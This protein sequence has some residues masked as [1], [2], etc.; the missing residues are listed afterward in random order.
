MKNTDWHD[1]VTNTEEHIIRQIKQRA[2]RKYYNLFM[3][4]R[5]H[6]YPST[7]KKHSA[8]DKGLVKP[9]V[10]IEIEQAKKDLPGYD[11]MLNNHKTLLRNIIQI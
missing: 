5:R 9:K 3:F 11:T 7:I 2:M 1:I 6:E 10:K 4:V 8:E